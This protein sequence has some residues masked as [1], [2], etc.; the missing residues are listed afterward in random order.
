MRGK[1]WEEAELQT[2]L[3]DCY[4]CSDWESMR[5]EMCR[6]Q[7]AGAMTEKGGG[8][9]GE[10]SPGWN[11]HMTAREMGIENLPERESYE[12]R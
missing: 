6:K 8:K 12:K 1:W 7:G 11:H 10:D 3:L 4:R 9:E 2:G 5:E